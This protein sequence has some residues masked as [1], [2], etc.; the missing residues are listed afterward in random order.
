[1]I[2]NILIH[3]LDLTGGFLFN[4]AARTSEP[5]LAQQHHGLMVLVG[6]SGLIMDNVQTYCHKFG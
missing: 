2:N 1:M 5:E 3:L 4:A 6:P